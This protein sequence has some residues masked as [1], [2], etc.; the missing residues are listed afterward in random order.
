MKENLE[1][2]TVQ[3]IEKHPTL[4]VVMAVATAIAYGI[5]SLFRPEPRYK[6]GKRVDEQSYEAKSFQ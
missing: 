2:R 6:D 5:Y 1:E 4:A 3:F